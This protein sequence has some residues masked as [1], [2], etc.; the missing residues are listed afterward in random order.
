MTYNIGDKLPASPIE[1]LQETRN[2]LQLSLELMEKRRFAAATTLSEY[3]VA[4]KQLNALL[5][6]YQ[7]MINKLLTAKE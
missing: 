5:V 2:E 7:S 4:I 3:E 1:S 6:E